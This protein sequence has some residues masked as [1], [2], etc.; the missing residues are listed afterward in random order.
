MYPGNLYTAMVATAGSRL[1]LSPNGTFLSDMY[2]RPATA[3]AWKA[4]PVQ[5]PAV[6]R[7]EQPKLDP[8]CLN[9]GCQIEKNASWARSAASTASVD[10]HVSRM[11]DHSI[12]AEA[13]TPVLSTQ[14]LL[15][16]SSS[17]VQSTTDWLSAAGKATLA[18]AGFGS[19]TAN[20]TRTPAEL[21]VHERQVAADLYSKL[22]QVVSVASNL[23]VT[24]TGGLPAEPPAEAPALAQLRLLASPSPQPS[25][26]ITTGKPGPGA[27][28]VAWA[29]ATARK[30][31]A[32][33]ERAVGTAGKSGA[34]PSV[35]TVIA[36]SSSS[37]PAQQKLAAPAAPAAAS[38]SQV[39]HLV[40][41]KPT[42]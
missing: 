40:V 35:V 16:Y 27:G 20:S 1:K 10:K 31:S 19:A 38:P 41:S 26:R 2:P 21:P 11:I 34:K 25:F 33:F 23:L 17:V 6:G 39:V 28:S 42:K 8:D 13:G 4:V 3:S 12:A 9:L 15:N 37:S 14:A 18:V 29:K 22:R 30:P 32:A 5:H 24:L 7:P 36:S